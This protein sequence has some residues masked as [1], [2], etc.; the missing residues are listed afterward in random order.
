[1]SEDKKTFVEKLIAVQTALKAPKGQ[2]NSFGKY[3]Y[4]SAEDILNAVKP[5]NAEQGLLLT[6][7]DE[8]LLIGD[9]HY[10]K[11][12]A[13]ITD[14][15]IKESFTA[16]ARESLTK[17]GMDDSQITGTASSYARKY[18]LNGLYLID[19]TKDADTDEYK[20]QEKN[21]KKIT[22][23]QLEQL[24]ANFQKIAAL[25]KVSE[26][27]VEAQ[28]LTIIKFDGKIED[29]DKEIHHKL[30]ELTNRNIHKLENE[31]FFNDVME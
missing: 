4:R 27:S 7:S 22:K 16:Y 24:R 26:K 1:M 25:K 29:L 18:A 15:I 8:P 20:K 21:V 28:F 23:K 13:T 12:T 3:K 11:A 10:I 17:K 19:D 31:Q 2:Y 6:L 5:L 9:W 30:M 14:G